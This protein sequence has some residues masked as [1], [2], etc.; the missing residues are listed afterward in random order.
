MPCVEGSGPFYPVFYD[1]GMMEDITRSFVDTFLKVA[2][3]GLDY[4]YGL[5]LTKLDL[6]VSIFSYFGDM[7]IDYSTLYDIQT[8]W[9]WLIFPH[10]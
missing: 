6:A 7:V 10:R 9:I 1:R 8:I 2:C 4:C 5:L 3:Y